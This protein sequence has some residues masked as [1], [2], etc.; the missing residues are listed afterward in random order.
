MVRHRQ[1]L[2]SHLPLK[3][4]LATFVIGC[5][6]GYIGPLRHCCTVN[7]KMRQIVT[8]LNFLYHL[9]L[10]RN[11]QL[12]LQC[13]KD[14]SLCHHSYISFCVIFTVCVCFDI[15]S[16]LK[17]KDAK[18]LRDVLASNPNRFVSLLVPAG[19]A[20]TVRPGSPSTTTA[21]LDLQ[22]QAI[23]VSNFIY[24]AT[25]GWAIWG[26]SNMTIFL[27]KYLNI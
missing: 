2:L 17:H 5:N 13:H 6:Q 16:F 15:Q 25:K 27:I 8:V 3:L 19:T 4:H 22:F 23:K 20:A 26:T 18:P 9:S 14:G 10:N 11:L 21:R 7:T 1:L 24:T 12:L